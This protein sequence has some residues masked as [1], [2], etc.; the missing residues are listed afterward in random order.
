ML[1]AQNTK[2]G[3]KFD[4]AP[5]VDDLRKINPEMANRYLEHVVVARRSPIKA[6]HQELL[7]RLLDHAE[8]EVNDD[9]VKYHLEELGEWLA[10]RLG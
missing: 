3:V 7:D 1:Y 10:A 5:L 2:S 9:G 6:L 8:D 4:E